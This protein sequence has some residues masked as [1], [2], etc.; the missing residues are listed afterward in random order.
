MSKRKERDVSGRQAAD[1]LVDQGR[2][3]DAAA[4]YRALAEAGSQDD[5]LFHNWGVALRELGRSEDAIAAFERAIGLKPSYAK[6][7]HGLSLAYRDIGATD[8]ALMAIELAIANDPE[9]ETFRLELIDQTIATGALDA[10]IHLADRFDRSAP[11]F[12]IAQNLM[13]LAL[14][15]AGSLDGALEAFNNAIESDARFA[16]PRQNRANLHLRA[17]RFSRAVADFDAAI[18][19]APRTAWL[20]GLRLYAAMHIFDW[21]GLAQRQQALLTAVATGEPAAQPLIVQHLTDDPALQQRAARTWAAQTLPKPRQ[22]ERKLGFPAGRKIRIAYVSRDF[23]NHPVAYLIAEVLALHDR[24]VFDVAIIN[25]GNPSEDPM[26]Q[27]LRAGV[28]AFIDVQHQSDEQIVRICRELSIDIAIDLTG[29]TD[30]ARSAIFASRIAPVQVLYLGYLGTSGSALYDYVVADRHLVDERTR[31]FIDERLLVLPSYQAN[32]RQ[33]PRPAADEQRAAAGLPRDAFVFCCFNNPAK[34]TPSMFAAWARILERVPGSVLWLLAE[35]DEAIRNL[36]SHAD[37]LGLDPA[38]LVFADRCDR[39]T[40]LARLASADL[41]LDT[42]PYNAGTTASDALWM[43]LPVLTQA[44]RS[45]AG[46]MASSLLYA[47]GMPDLVVATQDEYIDTA[48]ALA[49]DGGRYRELRNRLQENR[50]SAALFDTPAFTRSLELAY[51]AALS[52]TQDGDI[53]VG[54]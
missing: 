2:W 4:S 11:G 30:H 22:V 48:V 34:L 16:A 18:E 37:G 29:Y 25:Y 41:F 45:F 36:R 13:G 46:R 17:R 27:R 49:I 47:V 23:H 38:R 20:A 53:V 5:V 51:L 1:A 50:D 54:E 14:C 33:R 8:S 6:A 40:Y 21:R 15:K 43:G 26:Q 7:F 24:Q 12:A 28:D 32:D 31:G 9:R 44:G 19:L 52:G 35:E 39:E 42:L 3:A 10:A